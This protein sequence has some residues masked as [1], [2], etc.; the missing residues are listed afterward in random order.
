MNIDEKT[1]KEM[2]RRVLDGD[3]NKIKYGNEIPVEVSAR[4]VHLS[5]DDVDKLFGN[6]YRLTY[7]RDLSQTGQYLCE[8]RVK[9]V[10]EKSELGNVAILGPV[11]SKT[12]VEMSFSDARLFNI[13]PPVRLSG[14]LDG[15]ENIF[16][17]CGKKMIEA[18]NS[19]I[20]AQNH[21][22]M[23]PEDADKYCLTHGQ[24]VQVRVDGGRS[25][26]FNDVPVRIDKSFRLAMHIDFDEANAC[27]FVKNS[28]GIIL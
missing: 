11:R 7:K 16:I 20:I 6:G 23:T 21:I 19:V 2:V 5:Q 25:V 10:T 8:E 15:A 24:K 4:H 27:G 13:N 1:I 17:I 26:I 22:H 9:L 12:Q 3:T 14:N 18:K 28:F